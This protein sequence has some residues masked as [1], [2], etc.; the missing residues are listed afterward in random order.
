VE[1]L[2]VLAL[3]RDQWRTPSAFVLAI[4]CGLTAAYA[5][6]GYAVALIGGT[7]LSLTLRSRWVV[8]VST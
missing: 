7:L 3:V 5:P 1:A 4:V 2:A 8:P 6:Y